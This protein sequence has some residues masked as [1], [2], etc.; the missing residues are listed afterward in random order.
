M[1]CT[2]ADNLRAQPAPVPQMV[3]VGAGAM[4]VWLTG[5]DQRQT[6]VPSS[7]ND[8]PEAR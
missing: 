1:I 7:M 2:S 8:Y 6:D 5:M 3:Q 4:R